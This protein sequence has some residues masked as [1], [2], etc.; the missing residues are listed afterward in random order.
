MSKLSN[1][2][3][4]IRVAIYVRVSTHYQVDKDSLPLQREELV[5]YAK[6]VL[7]AKSHEVFEDAGYSAK[8]TD[9]PDYQQMMA[10]VRTGEFSHILVWK[11]DRISRN[12]LDFATMYDEL[13]KLGVTFVSKNEQ[14]DT[15]SAMGE[16]MLK[17]IL[18]F[19]ELERKMTAERVTAVMV[20]RA[21][22]G[23]WNGGRIPYG[24]DY[25]KESETFSINPDEEKIVLKIFELYEE[26]QS[27]L[28]VART[29]NDSGIRHRSGKEWSPTTVS[30]ILKNI[31]YTG[32][33]R[34]NY[35]DMSKRGSRQD[36]KPES[37]WVIIP[38]HHPA[39]ITEERWRNVLL[40]LEQNRRGWKASGKTYHRKNVH[41]FAGLLT[42][43]LCG[44]TMSATS[45]SRELK[46]G[47][48]PS[49]YACMSHRKGTGC[50]NKYISDTVLGPFVLNYIANLI[51]AK[52]SFGKTTSPET[53]HKKILR[54]DMFSEVTGIK[55]HGLMELYS[56]YRSQIS[57]IKY[58]PASIDTEE[59]DSASERDILLS[60]RRRIERALS[61]LK[62][63]YLYAEADM[64]EKDYI[65]EK[66]QLDEQLD[67]VNSR[68]EEISKG[69]TAQFS[70]SDDELLAKASYF[71]MSQK[72][73]DK[74]FVN[75]R[76]LLEETD[77]RILKD[78]IN[79][80]T[81]NFCI[82][83]GKIRSITFKN[84][85]IHEFM[86]KDD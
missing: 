40:I 11:L 61:R 45:S 20:S 63:L 26:R 39:I 5:A 14:F 36:I 62:T 25:D 52:A 12:L 29:L 10:R 58:I 73:S 69:L 77:P 54:G 1:K 74:R 68:L 53:L 32:A 51:K 16:A 66:K 85:I 82:E 59:T 86:Y 31:F 65:I 79:T 70:I 60:E 33:Y 3:N 46:G 15:S 18:V 13:K 35:F 2:L 9:R 8:N 4:S 27:I 38:E 47:Y 55:E 57:G 56:L 84:G 64:A 42:C 71:I 34:Y 43:Q 80:V 17:I 78:F 28:Y 41:V 37:E 76:R 44:A 50:T 6:Y 49:I 72:L 48:R 81:C 23:Q 21:G 24:Y 19:A 30:I 75:Y 22:T 83:N 7:N 67:K